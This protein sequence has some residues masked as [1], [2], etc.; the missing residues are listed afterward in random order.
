[1]FDL[2]DAKRKD[3]RMRTELKMHATT[4]LVFFFPFC[5]EVGGG[6]KNP[7]IIIVT[8]LSWYFTDRFGVSNFP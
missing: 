3:Q 4:A 1:M 2:Y 5:R 6:M 8:C 7:V